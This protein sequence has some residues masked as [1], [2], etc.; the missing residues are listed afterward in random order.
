MVWAKV[1]DHGNMR[2]FMVKVFF[3]VEGAY[4]VLYV[5][6]LRVTVANELIDVLLFISKGSLLLVLGSCDMLRSDSI[7]IVGFTSVY[8]VGFAVNV[9]A[10]ASVVKKVRH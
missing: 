10:N 6:D 4:K 5:G 7:Y 3:F 9:D 1:F 8:V 2:V